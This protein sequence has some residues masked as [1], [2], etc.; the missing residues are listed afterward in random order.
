MEETELIEWAKKHFAEMNIGGVWMPEG[1]GLAYQKSEKR[2]WKLIRRIDNEESLFNHN[3][4]KVLMFDAGYVVNDT[5]A[6]IMPEPESME[7]AHA[8]EIAMKREIAQ[9]WTDSDG[10][11]LIDMDL[12]NVWP[13][14]VEDKEMMLDNGETTSIEI[15][16]YKPTNPN[17]GEQLSIDPDDYHLLMGDQY[18]MRFCVPSS[19][20]LSQIQQ[21]RAL[22]RQEMVE[23]IDAGNEGIGIGSKIKVHFKNGVVEDKVPPWMW[24]TYC[25]ETDIKEEE[26]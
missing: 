7:E 13:E 26:E 19:L 23:Y 10:T 24:G 20:S 12:E 16:A 8:Q 6:E 22:S 14:F 25:E 15:W 2:K 17:T 4:M 3:K 21:F 5:D 9:L 11:L 1:S 18:F